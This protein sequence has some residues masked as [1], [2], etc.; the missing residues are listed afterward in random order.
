MNA[1]VPEKN[2]PAKGTNAILI[3]LFILALGYT[4]FLASDLLVPIA[5]AVL[6]NILLSPLVRRME[7]IG[8]GP[9]LSAGIIMLAL[10][11]VVATA[12]SVLAE[13][14][15]QWL[16]EAPR[17]VRQLKAQIV[18]TKGNLANIQELAEEVDDIATVE[19]SSGPQPVVL[20]GPGMLEGFLGGL[21]YIITGA[22]IVTF[23]TYFLLASG[24]SMLR[25][26]TRCARTWSGRRRIVTIARDIQNDLSTY[27]ATVTIINV[28]LGA[29]SAAI[30]YLLEFP[31]PLLWGTMVGLLNFA[32]YV[33]AV[34]S[35]LVLTV[36]GL[37]STDTLLEALTVPLI[38]TFLTVLEGQLI[39][40]SVLGTRMS[41]NQTVIFV[42]VLVWGWLWGVAGA[43][44][45]VPIM[46]SLKVWF[47]HMPTHQHLSAFLR[48]EDCGRR[49]KPGGRQQRQRKSGADLKPE[50]GKL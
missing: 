45:A 33:G 46:T 10:V 3:G 47:D 22:A 36:V 34:A 40:P 41:L 37:T 48:P 32:P 6:L 5:F 1:K 9:R 19:T 39:T 38:T 49:R 24:D 25:R 13:P 21:P 16:A 20:E 2:L 15:E 4:L 12:I 14:A 17:T 35:I 42:S 27:L 50:G 28:C 29:A 30:M 26:I 11:A 18:E 23:L 31:N 8:I 7:Q 44:M 43:L